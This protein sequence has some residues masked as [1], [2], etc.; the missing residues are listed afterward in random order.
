MLPL[1]NWFLMNGFLGLFTDPSLASGLHKDNDTAPSAAPH[2]EYS[3][4]CPQCHVGL[5]GFQAWKEHVDYAHPMG[6]KSPHEAAGSPNLRHQQSMTPSPPLALATSTAA[7]GSLQ[8][9]PLLT[10]SAS[11][12]SASISVKSEEGGGRSTSPSSSLDGPHACVQCS[13]SFQSRDLLEKH[14]LLHSP[15]GTV[16]CFL[17]FL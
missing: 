9:T 7:S 3:I 12:S 4:N 15:N 10:S 11:P 14:E 8:K 5:P 6:E 2:T 17:L 1:I 16:V 13:A